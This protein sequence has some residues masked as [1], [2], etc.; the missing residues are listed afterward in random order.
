MFDFEKGKA[1][2]RI[3]KLGQFAIRIGPWGM[4]LFTVC[5]SVLIYTIITQFVSI[6][7]SLIGYVLSVLMPVLLTYPMSLL[8]IRVSRILSERQRILDMNN[9]LK[10]TLLSVVSHD[11]K[12]PLINLDAVLDMYFSKEIQAEELDELLRELQQQVKVNLDF[13]INILHWTRMQYDGFHLSKSIF[14]LEDVIIRM[15]KAYDFQIKKKNIQV[16]YEANL[17]MDADRDLIRLVLRNLLANA[18]KFSNPGGFIRIDASLEGRLVI[19]RVSDNGIGISKEKCKSIFDET[20]SLS[21]KGTLKESG[22][23]LGLRLCKTFIKEHGGVISVESEEGKGSVF[24][25]SIPQ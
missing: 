10:N 8:A 12:G 20:I 14:N 9:S 1:E 24:T 6:D 16:K 3:V 7:N 22:T 13:V 2:H 25:F 15:L 11:V 18:I 4:T 5:C 19:I 17:E 21:E 23:G